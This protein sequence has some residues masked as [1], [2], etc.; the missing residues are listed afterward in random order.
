MI[1]DN[2]KELG[3][4]IK[5]G[6]VVCLK[7]RPGEKLVVGVIYPARPADKTIGPFS[8]SG[9]PV[10]ADVYWTDKHGDIRECFIPLVCLAKVSPG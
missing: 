3:G 10:S 5:E 8:S 6:D 7:V 1:A 9:C 4:E 2:L